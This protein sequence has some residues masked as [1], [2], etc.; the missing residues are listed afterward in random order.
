M[1]G[2]QATPVGG[3]V[4]QAHKAG[5]ALQVVRLPGT[6]L[7]ALYAAPLVL[8]RPDHIVAWRGADDTGAAAVMAQMLGQSVSRL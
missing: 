2:P 5:L 6:A 8:I 7:L 1:L 4:T 3:F